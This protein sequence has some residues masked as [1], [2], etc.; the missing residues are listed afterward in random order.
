MRYPNF[1]L[2]GK[3]E[4][5]FSLLNRDTR[6]RQNIHIGCHPNTE[7]YVPV[8]ASLKNQGLF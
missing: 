7:L 6:N 2:H 5:Y 8:F 4:R 3:E 1:N